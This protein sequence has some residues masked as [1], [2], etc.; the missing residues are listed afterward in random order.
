[1]TNYM[2]TI[3]WINIIGLACS[4]IATLYVFIGAPSASTR[5]HA[6]ERFERV[7]PALAKLS[8]K[9]KETVVEF[10]STHKLASYHMTVSLLAPCFAAAICLLNTTVSRSHLKSAAL[11]PY[12]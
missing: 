1:M 2:K 3:F 11:L 10:Y 4:T 6:Q 7:V 9:E 12:S 5:F 8:D